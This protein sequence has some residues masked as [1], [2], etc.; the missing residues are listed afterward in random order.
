MEIK[1]Y[2]DMAW[3]LGINTIETVHRMKS[4]E[5]IQL[6]EEM[7][8]AA[9]M[10]QHGGVMANQGEIYEA[11]QRCLR[12]MS[13]LQAVESM[14]LI[15]AAEYRDFEIQILSLTQRL[16]SAYKSLNPTKTPLC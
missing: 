8:K 6:G 14:G 9:K 7:L 16:Q 1:S 11:Y 5:F 3:Q 15:S 12:L 10:I 4:S 13:Y 2:E